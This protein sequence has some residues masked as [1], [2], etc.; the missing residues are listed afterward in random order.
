MASS[1]SSSSSSSSPK[2]R[3]AVL[4]SG[5]STAVPWLQCLISADNPCAVCAECIANP[6]SVNVRN[7]VSAVVTYDGHPD[8]R[9]RHIMIDAGKTMRASVG[10]WFRPLGVADLDAVLITHPHADAYLGLDDLR[11]I[12]PRKLL[13]VYLTQSCFDIVSSAFPYLTNTSKAVTTFVAKLDFRI[14]TPWVP[15]EI[16]EAG[17]IVTPI[18]VQHGVHANDV[19]MAFEFGAVSRRPA[20]SL[21]EAASA[22]AGSGPGSG[23]GA[24]T[25]PPVA[26]VPSVSSSS[27]SHGPTLPSTSP[28]APLTL[29]PVRGSRILW[30][31]DVNAFSDEVRAYILARP[32]DLLFLDCLSYGAYTTHFA[33]NQT[34]NCAVDLGARVCRFVGMSHLI[35]HD[36]EN[37]NLRTWGRRLGAGNGRCS[38]CGGWKGPD[39][40]DETGQ[41]VDPQPAETGDESDR[42]PC[43][44]RPLDLGLARDGQPFEADLAHETTVEE[45]QEEIERVR[46]AAALARGATGVEEAD[47][48]PRKPR[49]G[50]LEEVELTSSPSSSSTS[51]SPATT[52]NP[53]VSASPTPS[54]PASDSAAPVML[55][56]TQPMRPEFHEK[57]GPTLKKLL[58]DWSYPRKPPAGVVSAPVAATPANS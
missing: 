32:V 26:A 42:C 16:P 45:L 47:G 24:T 56:Y 11:D 38:N 33:I 31:S 14:I 44:L 3:F 43:G 17:V 8:G 57:A 36:I 51:L 54:P 15:F 4:G 34:V 53:A 30:I 5:A 27:S 12:S 1:S 22:G 58:K 48:A 2:S 52:P 23:A 25:I 19:C 40:I 20:P 35:H 7:N 9:K 39:E 10:K 55:H 29:P 18:P 28:A 37:G 41:P 46:A 6:N 21:G 49:K 13:A 50:V